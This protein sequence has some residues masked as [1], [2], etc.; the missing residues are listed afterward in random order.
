M[1]KLDIAIEASIG[2]YRNAANMASS[3]LPQM[4]DSDIKS[5]L[6]FS[7]DLEPHDIDILKEEAASD[8]EI[9]HIDETPTNDIESTEF[10]KFLGV[11]MEIPGDDGESKVL[12]KIVRGTMMASS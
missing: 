11:Y 4:D 8:P 3:Q 12:A 6:A 1:S 9:P 5:Q 2:D 10:D 7:F